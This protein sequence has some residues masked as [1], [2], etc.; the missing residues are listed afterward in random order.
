M[1]QGVVGLPAYAFKGFYEE[2][3]K[4]RGMNAKSY[5]IS[6]QMQ[7]GWEEFGSCK[8]EERI[9]VLRRWHQVESMAGQGG[10]KVQTT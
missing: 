4:K 3:Q 7:Q 10:F 9:E 5:T 2:Y 6:A 1:R 8:V